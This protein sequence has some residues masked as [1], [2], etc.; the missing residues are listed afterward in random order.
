MAASDHPFDRA[1][2]LVPQVRDGFLGRTS[3]DY[4]NSIT[5]FG[6]ATAGALLQT[7]LAHPARLGDP[8]ALTVNFAG[9]IQRG[10]FTIQ[11]VPVRTGR[12]TQHWQVTLH[13]GDDPQPAATGTAVFALRRD[14]WGETENR[15]PD[16][17]GPAAL[18]RYA[19]PLQKP[20]LERYDIRY[21]DGDPLKGGAD[22]ATQCWIG[23]VPPRPLDFP[24]I[25]AY[26]DSF[27]P[28]LFVRRGAPTPISTVTMSV[29][30]HI[31]A[32]ALAQRPRLHAFGRARAN[33]FNGGFYD[34][35]GQLWAEDGALLA[36]THQLVWF[37]D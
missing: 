17:P 24:A 28:R 7:M 36:T 27:L 21:T 8:I 30:F 20:F 25:V 5:P 3:E 2:A 34:Q 11:A 9:P 1:I 29:N 14:T 4:W 10:E 32:A 23:D 6:G 13:Q 37:K 35:E 18:A 12:S 19:P 15:M 16:V 31:G 26:C 22:S 33:A